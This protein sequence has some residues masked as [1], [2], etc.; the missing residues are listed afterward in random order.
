[1]GWGRG[2]GWGGGGG[3][4]LHWVRLM[5]RAASVKISITIILITTTCI[6]VLYFKVPACMQYASWC[7]LAVENYFHA[8]VETIGQPTVSS[9]MHVLP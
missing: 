6:D 4:V 5:P 1:M 2:G 7:L 3:E 8:L 9:R